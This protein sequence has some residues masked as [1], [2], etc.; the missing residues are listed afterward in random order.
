MRRPYPGVGERS[1]YPQFAEFDGT[2]WRGYEIDLARAIARRLGVGVDFVAVTP[3]NRIAL[4][5]ADRIDLAIASIGDNTQRD[6][7]AH[8][9]RPHYY[10]V[11]DHPSGRA[12]PAA[13]QLARR[14]R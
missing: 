12:R 4:I 6:G 14:R 2:N 1:D 5:G 10:G 3:A 8:F 11:R 7:Q 13:F 9:A